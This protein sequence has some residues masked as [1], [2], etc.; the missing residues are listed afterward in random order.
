MRTSRSAH[1][2]R[3]PVAAAGTRDKVSPAGRMYV[4]GRVIDLA[5]K[6][7]AGVPIEIIGR[8]REPWLPARVDGKGRLLLGRG[9]STADGHFRLE[10]WRTTAARFFEVYALAAAPGFGLGWAELNAN[11]EEPAAEIRL[12]PEQIIRGKLVDINGQPASDVEL[13]VWS[14]GRPSKIG[15]F[16]GVNIGENI[17]MSPV[18]D[19]LKNWPRPSPRIFRADSRSREPDAKS[20]WV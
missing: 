4:V 10:A 13:K 5:G 6:A 19:E 16:D 14:V 9:V 15:T 12:R 2:D 3:K 18:R 20:W 8:P 1:A 7:I 11:A 17:G